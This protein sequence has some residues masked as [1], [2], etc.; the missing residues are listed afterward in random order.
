MIFCFPQKYW[1]G[2]NTFT[3][4]SHPENFTAASSLWR[5]LATQPLQLNFCPTVLISS[6]FFSQILGNTTPDRDVSAN[7]TL[8]LLQPITQILEPFL[9]KYLSVTPVLDVPFFETS[10]TKQVY[11]PN[12]LPSLITAALKSFFD[13]VADQSNFE[14]PK[15]F[16]FPDVAIVVNP[17]LPLTGHFFTKHPVSQN[18][19]LIC[20]DLYTAD[21]KSGPHSRTTLEHD[22]LKHRLRLKR[23]EF[24][25][26]KRQSPLHS[27]SVLRP[28][29]EVLQDFCKEVLKILNVVN[30]PLA[31]EVLANEHCIVISR[32]A[33][34]LSPQSFF[35]YKINQ[36]SLFESEKI[37]VPNA[38]LD[39]FELKSAQVFSPFGL[40]LHFKFIQI[41]NDKHRLNTS[42]LPPRICR[43]I[44]GYCYQ[45]GPRE[46]DSA[47]LSQLKKFLQT[48]GIAALQT[49]FLGH[50][51][52]AFRE[53]LADLQSHMPHLTTIDIG[54]DLLEKW[55]K[56]FDDFIGHTADIF[57][58]LVFNQH[59]FP[60]YT[61][62]ITESIREIRQQGLVES[63]HHIPNSFIEDFGFLFSNGHW[64]DPYRAPD[65]SLML[66]I[67]KESSHESEEG[68]S[69]SGHHLSLWD[70][71]RPLAQSTAV[72]RN[73]LLPIG[74]L[75]RNLGFFTESQDV[76]F[77][78]LEELQ[79]L[80]NVPHHLSDYK[81]ALFGV[82]TERKKSL[83][84]WEHFYPPSI[85]P[86]TP[87]REEQSLLRGEIFSK[88][89][90]QGT[91]FCVRHLKDFANLHKTRS[92]KL[93]L[94]T[95]GLPAHW[96][97][98]LHRFSGIICEDTSISWECEQMIRKMNI[99]VLYKIP[100]ATHLFV[101][102]CQTH[103]QALEGWARKIVAIE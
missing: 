60:Q 31:L 73:I 81:K 14:E 57:S 79:N 36:I 29:R 4:I 24:S 88:G 39:F 43:Y 20:L 66:Q 96:A 91:A 1:P 84:A 35:P 40:S 21:L 95:L 16:K 93:I 76:F 50:H 34:Y 45:Y 38:S 51:V 41:L 68:P 72:L 62:Q 19:H 13:R 46:I 12:I 64:I 67:I 2:Q 15:K 18:P 52:P 99:P 86:A 97:G 94:I 27:I 7:L 92:K 26:T 44:N 71:K 59:A 56:I 3:Q 11:A 103:L 69:A 5:I 37:R 87:P 85:L 10:H 48:K 53:A 65:K 58:L 61:G 8:E 25:L 70:Y 6:H 9:G 33:A 75:F 42:P 17:D 90:A 54:K 74:E 101:T 23:E 82:L 89:Q 55:V 83:H 22:P 32:V 80:F 28:S 78:T 49:D 102:G 30:M 100:N 47:T 77:F 98:I 63:A